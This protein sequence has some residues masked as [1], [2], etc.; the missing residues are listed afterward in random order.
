MN[1]QICMEPMNDL[2]KVYK[3]PDCNHDF[4]TDC[5][6]NW[7]R[8]ESPNCI[9][10]YPN[11][12]IE[13]NTNHS[14]INHPENAQINYDLY[15][16]PYITFQQPNVTV[17]PFAVVS[18]KARKNDAPNGLKKLYKQYQMVRMRYAMA[19]KDFSDYKK[20]ED[21]PTYQTQ[22]KQFHKI[23]FKARRM[24]WKLQRIKKL[25]VTSVW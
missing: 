13:P 12:N 21:Y 8:N 18:R 22:R 5:I 14:I 15:G 25:L 11:M 19:N 9:A 2:T 1:C 4:H 16:L 17:T 23:C 3:I 20:T 10:C 6:V 7:F 24:K